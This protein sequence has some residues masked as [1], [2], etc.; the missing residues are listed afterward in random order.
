M[1]VFTHHILLRLKIEAISID[2]EDQLKI[3]YSSY[4][5]K[6]TSNLSIVSNIFRIRLFVYSY[7]FIRFSFI[8]KHSFIRKQSF[9]RIR[10][11]V[12][13]YSYAIIRISFQ[14]GSGFNC[15]VKTKIRGISIDDEDQLK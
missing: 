5:V 8:H 12:L 3:V 14:I 1:S 9:I 7:S 10:L 13:V 4:I 6:T 11:F 15:I 2:D